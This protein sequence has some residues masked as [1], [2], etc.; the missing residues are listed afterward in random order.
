M[1]CQVDLCSD[2]CPVCPDD[3][4]GRRRRAVPVSRGGGAGGRGLPAGSSAGGADGVGGRNALGGAGKNDTLGEEAVRLARRLRVISPQDYSIIG[5]S[6]I[7]LVTKE[8][9]AREQDMCMSVSTFVAGLAAMLVV[10][11]ASSLV[12]AILC[13]R[14]R[15]IPSSA[16]T[17]PP[18][19]SFHAFS[20]V[21]G[22]TM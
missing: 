7:T 9:G 11:V 10:L 14:V 6:P 4:V 17:Y 19:S 22:K 8:S 21:S 18:D 1:E 16:S 12:T 15:T 3:G 2:G 13:V 20:T 5:D